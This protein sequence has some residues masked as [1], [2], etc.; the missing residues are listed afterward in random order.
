MDEDV[1]QPYELCHYVVKMLDLTQ[2]SLDPKVQRR[3]L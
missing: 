2:L 3:H 1:L